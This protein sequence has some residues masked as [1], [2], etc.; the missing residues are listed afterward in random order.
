M[1]T[2][3]DESGKVS[4]VLGGASIVVTGNFSIPREEMKK[5]IEAY[6]GKNASSVSGRTAYL[7]AGEKCGP[8]KMKKA[9]KLGIRVIGENDFYEMIGENKI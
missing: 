4:D 9:E 8:E 6:G 7:L 5:K 2:F 1:E 3:P